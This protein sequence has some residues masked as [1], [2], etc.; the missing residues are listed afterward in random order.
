MAWKADRPIKVAIVGVG[1]CASAIVQGLAYYRKFGADQP[2]IL[3]PD[4]GGYTVNDI[5]PV[6][7]FD[8]DQRKIGLDLADAVYAEPVICY[9]LPDVTVP[10]TGVT[11]QMG[12]PMDGVAE[13]FSEY[14]DVAGQTP[15]DVGKILK[16]SGAEM[17]LNFLPTGSGQAARF[18]ADAAIKEAKIGFV[19]GM[20]ELIV[21]DPAYQK[22]AVASGV[23]LIGDDVKSQVGATVI[24]QML[25]ELFRERG[26]HVDRTYQIN[27]AGNSDFWML[28]HR[29]QTKHVTKKGAIQDLVPEGSEV[30]TGFAHVDLMKDRKTAIFY[31]E[32]RNFGGAPMKFEAKLEV[33]DNPNFAGTMMAMA[34]YLKLGLDRGSSGVL[35]AAC[36]VLTKHPPKQ[37]DHVVAVEHLQQFVEGKR[38]R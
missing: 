2:G 15:E 36:A 27:Y 13:E 16:D 4:I 19:N 24:H 18:Y 5:V 22:A 26:I 32:A 14:I 25:L 37:M 31:I 12:P 20:P 1:N 30:S 29:G 35:D 28:I 9:R 6:A 11:V 17:L 21:S 23:P 7:A 3:G 34:R 8:I 10:Q 33:E 38:Q